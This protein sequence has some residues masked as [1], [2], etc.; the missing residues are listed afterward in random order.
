MKVKID[1]YSLAS[2]NLEGVSNFRINGQRQAQ[3]G[4]FLRAEDVKVFNRKNLQTN[5]SFTVTRL[6]ESLMI[7]EI[8]ILQHDRDVPAQGLVTFIAG[9]EG[10]KQIERYLNAA[11]IQVSERS[12]I[13]VST[14]H[15]YTIIGGELLIQRPV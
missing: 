15:S 14:M 7:A 4:Q 9:D 11:M 13:G 2:G 3:I 12:F 10:G 8:F 5:V 6:H 1:N